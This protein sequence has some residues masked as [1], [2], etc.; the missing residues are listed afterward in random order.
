MQSHPEAEV[1]YNDRQHEQQG[2]GGDLDFGGYHFPAIVLLPRERLQSGLGG[3]DNVLSTTAGG[4]MQG[5][6]EAA[7]ERFGAE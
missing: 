1:E 4:V 2:L 5:G 6:P 3:T 7:L